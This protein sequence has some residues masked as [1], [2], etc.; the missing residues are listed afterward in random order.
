VKSLEVGGGDRQIGLLSGT[1]RGPG[2]GKVTQI[3]SPSL[4]QISKS[5]RCRLPAV[6]VVKT[7]RGRQG[8]EGV[9]LPLGQGA[10]GTPGVPGDVSD[11]RLQANKMVRK[12]TLRKGCWREPLDGCGVPILIPHVVLWYFYCIGF[13]CIGH[14]NV[15][16]FVAILFGGFVIV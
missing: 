5:P 7:L 4:G 9:D 6:A 16:H 14:W 15:S 13:Y 3:K 10:S 12:G 1:P 8:V 2:A 11:R